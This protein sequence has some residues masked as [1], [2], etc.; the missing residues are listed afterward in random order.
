M[1]ETSSAIAS[2]KETRL[3]GECPA[4]ALVTDN[5]RISKLGKHSKCQRGKGLWHLKQQQNGVLLP[6]VTL[7][8]GR[9][10]HVSVQR[11][12]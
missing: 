1:L 7:T 5:Q 8:V 12:R 3:Q 4:Q 2:R 10:R 6:L 11:D 9:V